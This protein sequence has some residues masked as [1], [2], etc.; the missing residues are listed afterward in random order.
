MTN[1]EITA[2]LKRRDKMLERR[3]GLWSSKRVAAIEKKLATVPPGQRA[4]VDAALGRRSA[5]RPMYER[6]EKRE[7]PASWF[8]SQAVTLEDATTQQLIA[9]TTRI[10]NE[11]QPI[12]Y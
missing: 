6:N 7:A 10:W 2:L 8:Q 4:D 9:E 3:D 1:A 5:S 11:T 12:E